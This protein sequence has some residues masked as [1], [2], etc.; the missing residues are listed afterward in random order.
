MYKA[1]K[2][3]R[4]DIKLAPFYSLWIQWMEVLGI[5]AVAG[6]GHRYNDFNVAMA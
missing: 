5:I 6:A 3:K 1:D 4:R 2:T